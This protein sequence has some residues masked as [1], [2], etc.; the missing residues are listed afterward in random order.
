MGCRYLTD[1]R[2]GGNL[3]SLGALSI[4]QLKGHLFGGNRALVG[5]GT[6]FPSIAAPGMERPYTTKSG[7]TLTVQAGWCS[8]SLLMDYANRTDSAFISRAPISMQ[9]ALFTCNAYAIILT[10]QSYEGFSRA[11]ISYP[12]TLRPAFS[13]LISLACAFACTFLAVGWRMSC[14]V[15]SAAVGLLWKVPVPITIM[16]FILLTLKFDTAIELPLRGVALYAMPVSAQAFDF[17]KSFRR[18]ELATE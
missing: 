8:S 10:N 13:H 12:A 1:R 5:N 9:A 3:S 6:V 15:L 4:R 14:G 18:R 11:C 16:S 17:L 7:A 2:L